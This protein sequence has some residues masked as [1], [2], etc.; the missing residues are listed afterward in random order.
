VEGSAS[1]QSLAL[2]GAGCG[3]GDAAAASSLFGLGSLAAGLSAAGGG[4]GASLPQVHAL[5][6]EQLDLVPSRGGLEA[7]GL[8]FLQ[9]Q[10]CRGM[11]DARQARCVFPLLGTY[12]R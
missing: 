8:R 1:A 12:P 4:N 9:L 7:A 6:L 10:V 3:G 11:V 5:L 2:P